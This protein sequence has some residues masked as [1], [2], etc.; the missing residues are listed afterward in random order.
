MTMRSLT[1]SRLRVKSS[2]LYVRSDSY[3]LFQMIRSSYSTF[4]LYDS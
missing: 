2:G 3:A 4:H 1:M